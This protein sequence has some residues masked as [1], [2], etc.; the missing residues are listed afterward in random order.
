MHRS[1]L[2]TLLEHYVP[3]SL[4]QEQVRQRVIDFVH[5]HPDCFER[6]LQIG[7]ITASAFV[8]NA[9]GTHVLLMHHAKL[10]AWMQLGG[11]CDGN[12]DVL[13]VAIKEAQ[14]ESG[15]DHI[16]PVSPAIFDIDIHRIPARPG[17]PEHDHYDIRFLLRVASNEEFRQNSESKELR[18]VEKNL[19]NLPQIEES[20]MRM[21]RAW[22]QYHY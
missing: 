19:S 14:E 18:W 5:A 12:S 2:L 11:H 17:E 10:D 4:E 16:V 6:S 8:L 1:N 7:H 20:V 22:R 21:V 15:I 13:A 3:Q 9:N